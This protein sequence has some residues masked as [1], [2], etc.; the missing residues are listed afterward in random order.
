[1]LS[2]EELK[3]VALAGLQNGAQSFLSS[4]ITVPT[5]LIQMGYEPHDEVPA[6]NMFGSAVF[7]R[8]SVF[9]YIRL[10][11]RQDGLRGL[12]RGASARFAHVAVDHVAREVV[13][14]ALRP[15]INPPGTKKSANKGEVVSLAH[16]LAFDVICSSAALVVSYPLQVISLRLVAQHVNN[17]TVYT[18]VLQG[19]VRIAREEGVQGL[20]AG[21]VPRLLSEAAFITSMGLLTFALAKINIPNENMLGLENEPEQKKAATLS[22]FRHAL[23]S[24]I[25]LY[26]FFPFRTVHV[27]MAVNG[28]RRLA[29]ASQ[30]WS[31]HFE[32]WVDALQYLYY[33]NGFGP[34]GLLRGSSNFFRSYKQ[35]LPVLAYKAL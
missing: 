21:L 5:L 1:M 4:P 33:L 29:V 3:A 11:Y 10:I 13:R 23:A 19:L 14:S 2:L 24:P 25:A 7:K 32:S 18:N 34:R 26:F 16:N 9:E 35:N 30:P 27:V 15:I 22:F 12:F 17:E 31:P 6:L 28:A 8:A 20:Y